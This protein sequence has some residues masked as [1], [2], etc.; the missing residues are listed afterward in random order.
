MIPTNQLR[1]PIRQGTQDLCGIAAYVT[2]VRL[3]C[4][5]DLIDFLHDIW[6]LDRE[7][8][9]P[10]DEETLKQF[11]QI[12]APRLFDAFNRNGRG[13]KMFEWLASLHR[14]RRGP[15]FR[16]ADL[17]CVLRGFLPE[18]LDELERILKGARSIACIALG[19]D[20]GTT[21]FSH[22]VNVWFDGEKFCLRDSAR[23]G[24]APVD[25]TAPSLIQAVQLTGVRERSNGHIT[26]AM[27][28]SE[29]YP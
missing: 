7:T 24:P 11:Y 6:E 9:E 14:E 2:A 10:T 1:S 25:G 16:A 19:F 8:T 4:G 29:R 5:S 27:S 26:G 13:V 21:P 23:G 28:V 3:F 20:I 18:E 12:H 22:V 17:A 15:N